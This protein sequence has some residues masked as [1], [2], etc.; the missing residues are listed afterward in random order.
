MERYNVVNKKKVVLIPHWVQDV[1]QRNKL[2]L[3]D[4]LILEKIKPLMSFNDLAGFVALQDYFYKVTGSEA[5]MPELTQIFADSIN[6]KDVQL[7]SFCYTTL[8][9]TAADDSV[10]KELEA[11]LFDINSKNN[12]YEKPFIIYDLTPEVCGV[13]IYPGY[14]F[15]TNDFG[16]QKAVIDEVLK[17]LYVYGAFHEVASTPFFKRHL[18]LLSR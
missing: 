8:I 4:C 3:A 6:E 12:I 16:L 9:K 11:R 18:E 5:V 2:Q 13:V 15:S 14:F 7:R 1:M 10:H 17:V